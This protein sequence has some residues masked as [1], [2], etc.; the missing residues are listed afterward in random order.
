[1][2]EYIDGNLPLT[3][4]LT[5]D[6]RFTVSSDFI[7]VANLCGYAIFVNAH[8]IDYQIDLDQLMLLNH[9]IVDDYFAYSLIQITNH[10]ANELER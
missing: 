8:S 10:I 3:K 7:A 4:Q 9:A 1:M 6:Y 2:R 5:A